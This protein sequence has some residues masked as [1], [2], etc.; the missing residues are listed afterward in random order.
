[1]DVVEKEQAGITEN[2]KDEF[3]KLKDS[4]TQVI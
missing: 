4:S 2:Q 3:N 1:M